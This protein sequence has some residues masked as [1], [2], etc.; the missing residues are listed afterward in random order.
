MQCNATQTHGCLLYMQ[1]GDCIAPVIL[2]A[3]DGSIDLL[4]WILVSS[5]RWAGFAAG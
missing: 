1:R 3:L 4:V 2:V 5:G